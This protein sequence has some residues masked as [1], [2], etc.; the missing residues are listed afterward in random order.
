MPGRLA[1]RSI[2]G[3]G[4]RLLL[5]CRLI[6]PRGVV[7]QLGERRV[8]NVQFDEKILRRDKHG[9]ADSQYFPEL[10]FNVTAYRLT[11]GKMLHKLGFI[12]IWGLAV[13]IWGP[14]D[15][16]GLKRSKCGLKASAD[17]AQSIG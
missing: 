7:A 3:R 17:I 5:G 13:A 6:A 11:V 8:R 1:M 15:K 2:L 16:C 10:G 12:E 14:Q 9:L 4:C